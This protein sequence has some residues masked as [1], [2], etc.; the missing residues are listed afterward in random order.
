[1]QPTQ[2]NLDWN[3][4]V[5]AII[6]L[7]VSIITLY[8]A[9]L[10]GPNIFIPS[11]SK[12]LSPF[13]IKLNNFDLNHFV[14]VNA[15]CRILF[16]NNGI[17]P[18]ILYSVEMKPMHLFNCYNI[19][20][21]I[22]TALPVCIQ[23]GESFE[24]IFKFNLTIDINNIAIVHSNIIRDKTELTYYVNSILPWM[25]K[26]KMELTIDVTDV[27]SKDKDDLVSVINSDRN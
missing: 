5:L 6:S 25:I 15:S 17:R 24:F 16:I 20:P 10:R 13:S 21:D 27:I 19:Q 26:R 23:P 22:L 7:V 1:M 18:G 12:S 4:S 11:K 2:V 3:V 9:H 14:E 8:L